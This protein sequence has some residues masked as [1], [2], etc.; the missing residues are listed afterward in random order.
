MELD[1]I[2]AAKQMVGQGLGVALLPPRRSP[3]SSPTADCARIDIEGAAPHPAAYGGDPAARHRTTAGLAAALAV[4][5]RVHEVLPASRYVTTPGWPTVSTTRRIQAGLGSRRRGTRAGLS[6]PSARVIR[7]GRTARAV[8]AAAR[9]V[10]AGPTAVALAAL[11][12]RRRAAARGV[13]R[14][15]CRAA[16][17]LA[18]RERD[19]DATGREQRARDAGGQERPAKSV[20]PADRCGLIPARSG[21]QLARLVVVPGHG[22]VSCPHGSGGM[23]A[24]VAGPVVIGTSVR[25]RRWWITKRLNQCVSERGSADHQGETGRGEP[26]GH[27]LRLIP[28]PDPRAETLVDRWRSVAVGAQGTGAGR[29]RDRGQRVGVRRDLDRVRHRIRPGP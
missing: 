15:G 21:R 27:F 13:G 12:G 8:R 23:R 22:F 4:L 29:L 5:D 28:G 3:R 7:P 9:I 24:R 10:G 11:R 20:W 6:G 17:G 18:R 26:L 2:D 14:R 19:G 1:N 16:E 25:A